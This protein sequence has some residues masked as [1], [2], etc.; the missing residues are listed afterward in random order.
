MSTNKT[1]RRPS[2]GSENIGRASETGVFEYKRR[3]VPLK[4]VDSAASTIQRAWRRSRVR[5]E[6]VAWQ[7]NKVTVEKLKDLGFDGTTK[8]MQSAEVMQSS[9]RLLH[10]LLLTTPA[11]AIPAC[12]KRKSKAPGRVFVTGFLFAAHAPLL[13][14]GTSHMD[15]MVESAAETMTRTYAEFKS[16]LLDNDISWYERQQTFMISFKAFNAA[17][18]SWKRSDSQL[19]L[20]TMERHYLELDRLWQ[21]V[22]RRTNGDGDEVWRVGIQNQRRDLLGKIRVLGG[23]GA[24]DSVVQKQR[25]LRSTYQDPQP[26]QTPSLASPQTMPAFGNTAESSDSTGKPSNTAAPSNAAESRDNTEKPG[27]T[28]ESRKTAEKPTAQLSKAILDPVSHDVDRILGSYNLTAS[29]ALENAKLAHELILDPEVRLRADSTSVAVANSCLESVKKG[30]NPVH[31][32]EQL[33]AEMHTIIPPSDPMCTTLDT[34]FDVEWMELQ[35][36]NRVLDVP[37]KLL[38]VLQMIRGVCAPIRDDSVSQLKERVEAL[39]ALGDIFALIHQ[40]RVDVLNY[41]LETV[42]RPWL[43]THAVEYE[44]EKMSQLLETQD[45][46]VDLTTEWMRPAA[47]RVHFDRPEIP[48]GDFAKLAFRE[49]LLDMCFAPVALKPQDTPATLALDQARIQELQNEIQVLLSTGALC[50]LIKGSFKASDTEQIAAAPVI[51]E[52]LRSESVTMDRVVEAVVDAVGSK[53]ES[54]DRLVRKTLAKDDPVYRA[55]E[56]GLRRFIAAQL[57]QKAP[58]NATLKAELARLSLAVVH[59]EVGALVERINRLSEFNWQ[60]HAQ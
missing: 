38:L 4:S 35:Q 40:V 37:A 39:D 5:R 46:D 32:L 56:N 31:V 16:S 51:L 42:V 3:H 21:T 44:R 28:T 45:D 20:A 10:A 26:S 19:L 25:D 49:A 59:K 6:M 27:N 50:A 55:M 13:V 7:T 33:R 58:A 2:A 1:K 41:Q 48:R 29:A 43:R 22:Q 11:T 23:D 54:I 53:G 36:K 18:D 52:C 15:T 47:T 17:F 14:T 57:G 8:L 9:D 60:V 24:V 30:A 34:E 12:D